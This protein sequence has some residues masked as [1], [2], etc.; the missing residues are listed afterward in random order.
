MSKFKGLPPGVSR[1]EEVEGPRWG[2]CGQ[3]SSSDLSLFDCVQYSTVHYNI[4]PVV[5][6]VVSYLSQSCKLHVS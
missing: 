1:G 2:L 6:F 4:L 5:F 3:H